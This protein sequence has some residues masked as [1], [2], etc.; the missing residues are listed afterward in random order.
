MKKFTMLHSSVVGWLNDSNWNVSHILLLPCVYIAI[1]RWSTCCCLDNH[2]WHYAWSL[3]MAW[4]HLRWHC[5]LKRWV[6]CHSMNGIWPWHAIVYPYHTV[7]LQAWFIIF[8]PLS[9]PPVM[10]EMYWKY[11]SWIWFDLWMNR[12]YLN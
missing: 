2:W 6:L 7:S 4:N 1:V 8:A 10:K 9:N 5:I 11:N 3:N 12:S